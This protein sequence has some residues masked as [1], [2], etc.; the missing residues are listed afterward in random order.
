[1][2]AAS[3]CSHTTSP[4]HTIGGGEQTAS[5][6]QNRMTTAWFSDTMISKTN[7]TFKKKYHK[8][9]NTGGARVEWM[10]PSRVLTNGQDTEKAT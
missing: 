10:S 5:A 1:M 6:A 2:P 3:V 7:Q 9:Y 4:Y 8:D